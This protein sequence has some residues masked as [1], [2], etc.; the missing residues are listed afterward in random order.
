M[1]VSTARSMNAIQ[2]HEILSKPR[3]YG[4]AIKICFELYHA[5]RPFH[6]RSDPHYPSW[7]RSF[8]FLFFVALRWFSFLRRLIKDKLRLNASLTTREKLALFLSILG[9]LLMIW[10]QQSTFR[11]ETE[12]ECKSTEHDSDMDDTLTIHSCTPKRVND[13]G[14]Y[15]IVRHPHHLGKWVSEAL[16]AVYQNNRVSMAISMVTLAFTVKRANKEEQE[17][18]HDQDYERYKRKV[19]HK[20]VPGIY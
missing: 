20:M 3:L 15:A 11:H 8:V 18:I 12:M 19:P 16:V 6:H 9:H 13:K 10:A 7:R 4:P 5:L 14:P 2:M 17:Y 1:A